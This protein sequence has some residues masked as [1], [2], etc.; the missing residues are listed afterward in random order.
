MNIVNSFVFRCTA[1][2]C[3]INAVTAV[4]VLSI[5]MLVLLM[6]SLVLAAMLYSRCAM[7]VMHTKIQLHELMA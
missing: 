7:T 4:V 5:L 6:T 3:Y 2:V 1:Y